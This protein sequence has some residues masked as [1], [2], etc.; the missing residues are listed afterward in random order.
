MVSTN[1]LQL[2]FLEAGDE[3]AYLLYNENLVITELFSVGLFEDFITTTAGATVLN[4]LYI[5]NNSGST[6]HNKVLIR[7]TATTVRVVTPPVNTILRKAANNA[8]FLYNG[9]NWTAY[10][11]GGS[12][13]GSGEDTFA[14]L[15]AYGLFA[16]FITTASDA[17]STTSFE[18]V[19]NTNDPDHGSVALRVDSTTVNTFFAPNNTILRNQFTNE[20]FI[21][22]GFNWDTYSYLPQL[23]FDLYD[24][25]TASLA[26]GAFED[27]DVSVPS[28]LKIDY[29]YASSLIKFRFYRTSAARSADTVPASNVNNSDD[30]LEIAL[31]SGTF[32]N[33]FKPIDIYVPSGTLYVRVYNMSAS[34]TT[35]DHEFDWTFTA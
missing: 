18:I 14:R 3:N 35:I 27:F 33:V 19:N 24:D 20:S 28:T 26:P 25:T 21:F 30:V 15:L 6:D 17:S 7:L 16:G 13:G 11:F 12:G 4:K 5:L 9:L 22:N 1:Q 8:A 23:S 31:T 10:S 2:D 32:K 34:T 29:I